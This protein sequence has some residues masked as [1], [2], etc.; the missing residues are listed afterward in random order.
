MKNKMPNTIKEKICILYKKGKSI[1]RISKEIRLS[2]WAL[3]KILIEQGMK[4]RS[5]SEQ[6]KLGISLGDIIIKKGKENHNFKGG[7]SITKRRGYITC[8][9]LQSD[10]SRKEFREHRLIWEKVNGEIP[11]NHSIHHLNGI[12]D[13]NRIENLALLPNKKH[14]WS[15]ILQPYKNRIMELEYLIKKLKEKRK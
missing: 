11:E 14:N 6:R 4:I 3:R 9:I 1:I 15:T 12:K 13:D 7:I 2:R 5:I 8:S 10:G